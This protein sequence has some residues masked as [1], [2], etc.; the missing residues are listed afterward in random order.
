MGMVERGGD[1][2][3]RIV[4]NTRTQ[5]LTPHVTDNVART[6]T[7]SSDEL[8]AYKQLHKAGYKHGSVNHGKEQWVNGIHHTN[9]I[10]SFWS[11]LKNSIRGTHIHV[12]PKYLAN[13][14]V[15]FEYRHNMRSQPQVMFNRLLQA[16]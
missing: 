3:T 13:C 9:T 6:A 11:R 12:S 14:L 4:P 5:T 7:I 15:E 2:I 1:V 10:E 16:F 8:H